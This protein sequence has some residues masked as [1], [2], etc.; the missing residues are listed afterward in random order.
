M[1]STHGLFHYLHF[2]IT[3]AEPPPVFLERVLLA[4]PAASPPPPSSNSSHRARRCSRRSHPIHPG[5]DNYDILME[6]WVALL[7][8]ESP[9]L[10]HMR[11][12]RAT[13]GEFA[14]WRTSDRGRAR[15]TD[16]RLGTHLALIKPPMSICVRTGRVSVCVFLEGPCLGQDWGVSLLECPGPSLCRGLR[17]GISGDLE[18]SNYPCPWRVW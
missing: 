6:R 7:T 15:Q 14:G 1:S 18:S 5:S 11:R 9:W 3:P 16:T 13:W 10:I 2:H 8:R 4:C 17:R 12:R